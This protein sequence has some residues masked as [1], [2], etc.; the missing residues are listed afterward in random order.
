VEE[1]MGSYLRW[2][3]EHHAAPY[4]HLLKLVEILEIAVSG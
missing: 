3:L 4:Q 1:V 2:L